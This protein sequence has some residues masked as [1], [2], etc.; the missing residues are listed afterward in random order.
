MKTKKLLIFVTVI[1][2]CTILTFTACD[3]TDLVNEFLNSF[4]NNSNQETP[5]D[6]EDGNS[7]EDTVDKTPTEDEKTP[8]EDKTPEDVTTPDNNPSVEDKQP[9]DVPPTTEDNPDQGDEPTVDNP[10]AEENNPT[11][12]NPP[13]EEN[14]PTVDNPPAEENNPTVDNP[15]AEEDNP[16]VDNTPKPQY[17]QYIRIK[18]ASLNVRSGVG[19]AYPV[20]A[21]FNQGDMLPYLGISDGW[22]QTYACGQICYVSGKSDYTELFQLEISEDERIEKIIAEGE[23]LLGTPY[24]YGAVRYHNGKGTKLSGFKITEFD[25]SSL[26]QY[27]FYKGN[28]SLLGL[29]TRNQVL[30]G[31]FVEKENIKRGDLLFFTNKTR[32]DNVGIERVGHV[33]LYLGGNYILHTATDYAVIE[34]ITES[35]W[36]FYLEARRIVE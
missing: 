7:D 22:Y 23:K 26:M 30:Q 4:L 27:I 31:T 32:Y 13:A 1:L 29:T 8:T 33:A 20:V 11:V 17:K 36:S 15:P 6:N 5:S 28:G 10:P 3:G 19:T 21:I 16:V 2:L 18:A 25:C 14:N 34:Y 35:R 24:V 12:D 9:E